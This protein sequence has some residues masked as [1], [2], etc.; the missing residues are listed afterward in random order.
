[1]ASLHNNNNIST[2]TCTGPAVSMR[3]IASM[4]FVDDDDDDDDAGLLA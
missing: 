4:S 2:L 1:M 3:L